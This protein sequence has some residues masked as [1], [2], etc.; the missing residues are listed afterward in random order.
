MD[1]SRVIAFL[2]LAISALFVSGHN[3]AEVLPEVKKMCVDEVGRVLWSAVY[4]TC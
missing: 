2:S 1:F 4:I 3:F